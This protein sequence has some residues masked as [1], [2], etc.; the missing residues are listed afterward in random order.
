MGGLNLVRSFAYA[1]DDSG[2]RISMIESN[3]NSAQD[4]EW[5]YRYDW[6]DRL[7]QVRRGVGGA[8]P[9]VQREYVFDESDNR[10]YL[11]DYVNDQTFWYT[12][13]TV[14][15][16]MDTLYSDELAEILVAPSAGERDPGEF[17]SVETFVTDEDGNMVSRNTTAGTV[18]YDWD[19]L[20]NL[21]AVK[22]DSG[23]VTQNLYD[24]G[25]IRKEK[26]R[27]N[28]ERIKS[29][30]SG[31]PTTNETSTNS[32]SNVSYLMGHQL[33]GFERNGNFIYFIN[34][35]LTSVR[36]LLDEDGDEVA[37]FEH[38][39]YGNGIASSGTVSSPKTYVG[40]LG[41]HDDTADT[42]LLYMRR[43][44]YDPR[45][46]IFLSRDPIGFAGDL[47]LYRYAGSSPV[48]MV[49]PSGLDLIVVFQ[50][51]NSRGWNA[52]TFTPETLYQVEDFL[53]THEKRI[54]G[55]VTDGH[56][57]STICGADWTDP[58]RMV[59]IK[60]DENGDVG[61]QFYVGKQK[62]FD[63]ISDLKFPNLKFVRARS[64]DSAGGYNE[65][66]ASDL[67]FLKWLDEQSGFLSGLNGYP[68][69]QTA[70]YDPANSSAVA[71]IV[72]VL[73]ELW[74]TADVQGN[75]GPQWQYHSGASNPQSYKDGKALP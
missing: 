42:R 16:G 6:L 4:I 62:Y 31:L 33:M 60:L 14:V 11:D 36:A 3:G 22:L 34:D 18:S 9:S 67:G 46:G 8:T 32:N 43:R 38:D 2:N 48:T 17:V 61:I 64:C 7:V 10:K 41:V 26:V 12:Y 53:R 45:L 21:L 39:E 44:H 37:T 25:S 20:N 57:N 54:L 58:N 51:D 29:F 47:N 13:K 65:N 24:A 75:M 56:G 66:A 69:Y 55:I 30:Y 72:K 68:P 40:G 71:P 74:P 28:E 59:G 49:D 52:K 19:D 50:K 27:D 73:S 15:D 63:S 1:Y 35:G 5:Q 70:P 23:E